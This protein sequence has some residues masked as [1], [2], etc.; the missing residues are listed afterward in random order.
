MTVREAGGLRRI[1]GALRRRIGIWWLVI[2]GVA[3]LAA[4]CGGAA[5][6]G[7]GSDGGD[8]DIS[9]IEEGV[10]FVLGWNTDWTKRTIDLSELI[11]GR[12]E[13]DPRDLIVPLD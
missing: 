8:E 1:A 9:S 4:A 11:K 12:P 5:T 6:T 2:G 3:F 7:S 13:A 10:P